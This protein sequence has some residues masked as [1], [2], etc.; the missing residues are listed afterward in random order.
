MPQRT[1]LST[2]QTVTKEGECHLFIT[3]DLNIT[4]NTD[5]SLR[6]TVAE[7]AGTKKE[8]KS[9]PMPDMDKLVYE[10]PDFENGMKLDF[11]KDIT[12]GS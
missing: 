4:L 9:T 10:I 5:G 7:E 6:T 1:G 3:L 11:G 8:P 2:V 12:D